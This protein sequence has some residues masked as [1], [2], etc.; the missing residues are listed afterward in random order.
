MSA[1]VRTTPASTA[2]RETRAIQIAILCSVIGAVTK[3]V[4][5]VITGSMSMLSS[6]I[7]SMGDLMVSVVNLFV[8]RIAGAEPDDDHNYG[9]A[10]VEGLGAMFEGGF[11]FAAGVFIVYEA[12]H[13]LIVG[14][15]SHDSVLGIVTMLPL[16][17]ITIATVQHLRKVAKET[18]SLVVRSDALHYT[19]DVWVNVGVLVSLVL[20]HLTGLPVIDSIVS[21]VIALSM[22]RASVHIVRDGIDV[23]MDK[24]LPPD[25]VGQ[26]V[27]AL[28]AHPAVVSV[29][30]L[31]TRGGKIP[32]VDFHCVVRPDTNVVQLHD[33]F[34][35]LRTR[36]RA[37]AGETAHVTMHADPEGHTDEPA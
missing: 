28:R 29:H 25:V 35:E 24:A 27:S 12:V 16:L 15:E 18:G 30:D 26:V 9:H 7:D 17:A 19:T 21:I 13:K 2:R 5:G 3:L 36:V 32:S 34:L 14:E 11:V 1:D 33:L 37:V 31:K 4:V 10:K 8:V 22:L 20:V 23:V 6:A